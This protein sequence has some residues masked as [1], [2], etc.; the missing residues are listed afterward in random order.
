MNLGII[1]GVVTVAVMIVMLAIVFFIYKKK[2]SESEA[3]ELEPA[4][5]EHI[6]FKKEKRDLLKHHMNSELKNK[7]RIYEEFDKIAEKGKIDRKGIKSTFIF[8]VKFYH[9][10]G[11]TSAQTS[12]FHINCI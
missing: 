10:F 11:T 8:E 9:S 12:V 3:M 2:K 4:D 1:A 5:S 6:I 7:K